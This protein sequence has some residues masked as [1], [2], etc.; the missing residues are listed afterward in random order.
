MQT[1]Q[2]KCACEGLAIGNILFYEKNR[3]DIPFGYITDVEAEIKRFH[4][5]G[6]QAF[7]QLN[8]IYE[9]ALH[10]LSPGD[11]EIFHMHQLLLKDAH[12][13]ASVEKLIEQK[14][15]SAE[16]AVKSATEDIL[17]Q[18]AA[19]D[20]QLQE[21]ASD[22][23]DVA[24]YLLTALQESAQQQSSAVQGN[25]VHSAK[26]SLMQ[27]S[28]REQSVILL[29]Q[30]LTPYEILQ[31]DNTNVAG[32]VTG[33]GSVHSHTAIL[34]RSMNLPMLLTDRL[35]AIR[36]FSGKSAIL[37]AT[38]STLYIDYDKETEE[39]VR[40][41]Y[42]SKGNPPHRK[43][44]DTFRDKDKGPSI[45]ANING[46]NDLKAAVDGAYDGIGLFRTEF[47]YMNC[48]TF[49]TEEEQLQ[50]Y[51][52]VLEQMKGKTVIIRTLDLGGDKQCAYW[53]LAKEDNPALGLRG[54]RL[55]LAH[56]SIF[57]VQL[58]ALLRA[59][60]Y[61]KLSVMYPMISSI[62][63]VHRI[64]T[65]LAEVRAELDAEGIPYANP[66]QGVMIETP[67]AVMIGPELASLVDFFSI[68][69]NDLTQYTLASDRQNP[70][71]DELYDKHHPAVLRMIEQ[72][73]KT[74]HQAGISVGICG[75]MA[76]DGSLY[77]FFQEIGVDTLSVIPV[78]PNKKQ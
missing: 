55:C 76:G 41:T 4:H 12:F 34:A 20:A 39:R 54:I 14:H 16:S 21:K 15:L 73:V 46:L 70:Q 29:T 6:E 3:A 44:D 18:F 74:A 53:S 64:Q 72:A 5:A 33:A 8:Q 78:K 38:A 77:S 11:A 36:E 67:A 31:L 65:L 47:L 45:Y 50:V 37:D 24:D 32:I 62:S 10:T 61:G 35:P 59:A 57:K 17:E 69:T 49:P 28:A 48:N 19:K 52:E 1:I 2:G 42:T 23:R 66:K 22:I 9:Q 26:S 7:K 27:L 71:M 56:P 43:A 58:R 25:I 30:E 13:Q 40:Y 63:E 75:D 60:V 68:G 51:K